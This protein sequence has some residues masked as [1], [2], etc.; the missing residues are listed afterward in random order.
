MKIGKGEKRDDIGRFYAYYSKDQ[1]LKYLKNSGY[2]IDEINYGEDVGLD[3]KLASWI[4]IRSH[5]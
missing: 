3:G 4:I 5:A 1:L 2:K